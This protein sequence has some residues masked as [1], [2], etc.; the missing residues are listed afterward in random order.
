MTKQLL[1]S[2]QKVAMLHSELASTSE[3]AGGNRA[4]MAALQSQLS[5][6]VDDV[7]TL[8]Q[9][10]CMAAGLPVQGQAL[11][12]HGTDSGP[13]SLASDMPSLGSESSAL[14]AMAA[15]G[16]NADSLV[17]QPTATLLLQSL[18]EQVRILRRAAEAMVKPSAN[19][20]A[21]GKVEG[22]GEDASEADLAEHQEQIVKLKALLSTKREQIATLRT[23]VKANKQTAEVALAN[24]KSKYETEKL[25]VSETMNK[26]RLELRILKAK[27][28]YIFNL[29]GPFHDLKA[30]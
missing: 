17:T 4:A 24:L 18:Q 1:E 23:V 6:L 7:T 27:N 14:M 21:G 20:G 19:N 9:H 30:L 2:E 3:L 26:L 22:S 25:I 11:R 16:V 10:L 15:P 8:A 5:P 13:S 28:I 29:I 12:N